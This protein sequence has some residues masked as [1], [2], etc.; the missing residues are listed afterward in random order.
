MPIDLHQQWF[1]GLG[2]LRYSTTAKRLRA[3]RERR[4]EALRTQRGVRARASALKATANE[5]A[6]AKVR[7]AVGIVG[8][9]AALR[10]QQPKLEHA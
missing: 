5:A 2:E 9:I 4:G 8:S 10:V 3:S 1:Q 7:A 6:M